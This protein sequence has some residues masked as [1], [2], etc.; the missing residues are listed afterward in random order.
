VL[1]AAQALGVPVVAIGGITADNAGTLIDAG[2][3]SLAVIADVFGHDDAAD[4]QRAA[5]A[6]QRVHARHTRGRT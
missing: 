4:V 5:D 6:I 2:A 1:A 3:D